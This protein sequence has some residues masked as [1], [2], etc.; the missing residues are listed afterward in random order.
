MLDKT[1]EHEISIDDHIT[2][3]D[4]HALVWTVPREGIVTEYI[5]LIFQ[6][7]ADRMASHTAV[8]LLVDVRATDVPNAAS[9]AEIIARVRTLAD[10]LSGIALLTGQ[11]VTQKFVVQVSRFMMTGV[12]VP[13]RMF[14]DVDEAH[15]WLKTTRESAGQ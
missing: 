13:F 11:S 12:P 2:S 3:S 5:H 15:A 8:S 6:E 9:R 4:E 10:K 1:E 14:T 7:M